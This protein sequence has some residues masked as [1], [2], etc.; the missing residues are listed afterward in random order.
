MSMYAQ[1]QTTP[2]TPASGE[3]QVLPVGDEELDVLHPELRALCAARPRPFG[4]GEVR[5]DQPPVGAEPLGRRE[6]RVPRRRAATS[7][8]VSPGRGSSSSTRRRWPPAPRTA[9]PA[10]SAAPSPRPHFPCLAPL[11]VG[12]GHAAI[13]ARR[14]NR[15][16]G[17]RSAHGSTRPLLRC[18]TRVVR[19]RFPRT[20]ARPDAGL[21]GHRNGRA[22]PDPGAHRLGEDARRLPVRHRPAHGRAG[23]RPAAA[24]RVAAQGAQLRRRAQ[25]ARARWPACAPTC[26]SPSAPATRRRRSAPLSCA[27]RQ[28]S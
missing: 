14:V 16:P 17:V 4:V 7:R 2:S 20:D 25:P 27:T 26:A 3:R 8:I 22:R 23:P 19:G 1:R 11:V 15:D 28:T 6:A 24:L 18:N 12:D 13:F 9:R 5:G 10:R 21:A